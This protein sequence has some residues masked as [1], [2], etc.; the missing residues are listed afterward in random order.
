MERKVELA[1]VRSICP[2][3]FCEKGVFRNFAKFTGKHLWPR[4]CDF[5]KKETLAQVSSCE[6][7]EISK[8]TFF[9]RTPRVVASV[10]F[11]E[12]EKMFCVVCKKHQEKLKKMSGFTKEY[13]QR[14]DNFKTSALSDHD[15]S[16]MH[17]QAVNIDKYIKITKCGEQYRP[18]PYHCL[19]QKML[20]F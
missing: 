5:I 6:F 1:T 20:P 17:M 14:S 2:E 8:N 9:Y 18:A 16:K 4:T 15:K 11:S 13:L 7:C 10:Q 12:E 3:V 19:F